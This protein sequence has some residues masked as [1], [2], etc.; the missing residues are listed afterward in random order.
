[1]TTPGCF[2]AWLDAMIGLRHTLAV[3]ATRMPWAEIESA[4]VSCFARKDR[5]GPRMQ[6]KYL[7]TGYLG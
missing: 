7:K 3:L 6:I 4:L 1:M 2:R 5:Q